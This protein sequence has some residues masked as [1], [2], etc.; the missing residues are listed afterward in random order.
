MGRRQL[1]VLALKA[2]LRGPRFCR[3]RV[4]LMFCELWWCGLWNVFG[5]FVREG[6]DVAGSGWQRRKIAWLMGSCSQMIV[7]IVGFDSKQGIM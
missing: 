7:R 4:T 3:R 5:Q 6:V 2:A 1:C